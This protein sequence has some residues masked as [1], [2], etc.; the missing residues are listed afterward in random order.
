MYTS[1]IS[2]PSI[3]LFYPSTC[4]LNMYSVDCCVLNYKNMNTKVRPLC[5]STH[6][7]F[8]KTTNTI[9]KQCPSQTIK[10][11]NVLWV[12]TMLASVLSSTN[13]CIVAL[14]SLPSGSRLWNIKNRN[15]TEGLNP[16]GHAEQEL[17]EQ[18]LIIWLNNNLIYSLTFQHNPNNLQRLVM[19]LSCLSQNTHMS[20]KYTS[21]DRVPKWTRTWN[22]I[23]RQWCTMK[24]VEEKH[25]GYMRQFSSS[26]SSM[27]DKRDNVTLKQGHL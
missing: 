5:T 7:T 6:I 22:F 18:L 14:I 19:H 10:V 21:Y 27:P 24:G 11:R 1:L 9:C 4:L 2:K 16:T 17:G 15:N 8:I 20:E 23:F 26:P 3:Q 25:T 13:C 12:V